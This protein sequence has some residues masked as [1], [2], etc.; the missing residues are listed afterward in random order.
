MEDL[1]EKFKKVVDR[2]YG[3]FFVERDLAIEKDDVINL[4][5]LLGLYGDNSLKFIESQKYV[6]KQ[7]G[8]GESWKYLTKL[9]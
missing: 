9:R 8:W 2:V 3:T 1:F 5:I 4:K 6:V 7:L